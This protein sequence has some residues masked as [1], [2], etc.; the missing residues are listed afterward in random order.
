MTYTE[1]ILQWKKNVKWVNGVL[2]PYVI[3]EFGG[4]RPDST[5]L[6]GYIA[7]YDIIDRTFLIDD[8]V[9]EFTRSL[10]FPIR[11]FKGTEEEKEK[12]A[13]KLKQE[14]DEF[15]EATINEREKELCELR[16]QGKVIQ[17]SNPYAW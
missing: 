9:L 6:G 1:V 3:K 8:D 16:K 13:E 15:L 14:L 11:F 2:N 10:Y 4:I 17:T 5:F 12:E 7:R